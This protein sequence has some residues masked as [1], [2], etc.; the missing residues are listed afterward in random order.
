MLTL[1]KT[2]FSVT[3]V[4]ALGFSPTN[5]NTAS[6]AHSELTAH[7][8]APDVGT[9]APYGYAGATSMTPTE[10]AHSPVAAPL[11]NVLQ[12]DYDL[13]RRE[14]RVLVASVFT[15]AVRAK[16]APDIILGVIKVESR[17]DTD[18]VS[19]HGAQG[20]M[21]VMPNVHRKLIAEHGRS[22]KD[23]K[24]IDFNIKI[25]SLIF[26]R[27]LKRSRGNLH[28]ALLRYNGSFGTQSRYAAHV[29]DASKEFKVLTDPLLRHNVVV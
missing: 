24:R 22:V 15:H 20:L 23:L 29:L 5:K 28:S 7:K 27:A 19:S 6:H 12:K 3:F 21:Q 1:K 10:L 9:T 11:I 18:A 25:G 14:A 17:F 2:L 8:Q 13:S 16:I 4:C 26:Q